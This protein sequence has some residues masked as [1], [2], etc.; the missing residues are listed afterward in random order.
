M[1]IQQVLPDQYRTF[2]ALPSFVRDSRA[3]GMTDRDELAMMAELMNRADDYPVVPGSGGLQKMRFA[4]PSRKTGK[5]GSCRVYYSHLKRFGVILLVAIFGKN[6]KSDLT[7]TQLAILT[8]ISH[9]IETNL[10]KMRK[11]Q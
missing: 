6:E 8:K 10:M 1:T 7:K 9:L 4:L 3:L 11:T 2:Y 5:R